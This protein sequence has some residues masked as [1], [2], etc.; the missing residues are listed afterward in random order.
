MTSSNT[1]KYDMLFNWHNWLSTMSLSN[2]HP[3]I[4]LLKVS[5]NKPDMNGSLYKVQAPRH[6]LVGAAK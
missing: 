2:C 6:Q 1:A 5:L 4:Y 3:N